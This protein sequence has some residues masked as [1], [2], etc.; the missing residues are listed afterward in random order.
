MMKGVA[1]W[2]LIVGNII[3]GI[4]IFL[5]GS[6]MIVEQV[7]NTGR[8]LTVD[9]I[10]YLHDKLKLT[11]INEGVGAQKFYEITLPENVRVIYVSKSEYSEPPDKVSV[12][13]SNKESEVGNY[14]CY[15]LW[16]ENLPKCRKLLCELNF[17]YI[18]T[19]SLKNDLPTLIARLLSENPT[20]KYN[21]HVRKVKAWSLV[22]EA[23]QVI[24]D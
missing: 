7:E 17:T 14:F 20:Y 10:A 3:F 13:I 23:E 2:V 19:P 15:Q 22:V 1:T 5:A 6:N 9:N 8:Q 18:G 4:V 12:L 21:L 11:C 24:N 16:D